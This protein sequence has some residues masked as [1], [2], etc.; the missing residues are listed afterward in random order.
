MILSHFLLIISTLFLLSTASPSKCP[1]SPL[2]ILL[3]QYIQDHPY[4]FVNLHRPSYA[5]DKTNYRP[6]WGIR[7]DYDITGLL[8]NGG[9]AK[10][11]K[12]YHDPTDKDVALKIYVH[13]PI[14][15]I[16]REIQ[17]LNELADAPNFLSLKDTL[18]DKSGMIGTVFDIFKMTDYQHLF[19]KTTEPQIRYFFYQTLRTLEY[20]H[21][22]G[23]MHRDIKPQNVMM[24]TDLLQM[25]LID[26][27]HAAYY[28]PGKEYDVKVAS[29]P[30]KGPELL[31]NYTLH[32]Y[33]TDIWS[34]GCLFGALLFRRMPFFR[35]KDYASQLDAIAKVLG[36]TKLRQYADKYKK[37]MDLSI[38]KKVG[39]YP[40][41][42]LKTLINSNNT[43]LVTNSAIDLLE[44]MLVYDHAKRITAKEALQH[45]YFTGL[46]YINF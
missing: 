44:Q 34:T 37:F 45:P 29:M 38:L 22:R 7:D 39:N 8:A 32:D 20:A 36:T 12:G 27:G 25:K 6:G 19:Y 35:G 10:V 5:S 9:F 31:L 13:S 11:F 43:H 33:S 24:N 15:S 1:S 40:S 28:F 18:K 46:E 17:I 42:K 2:Y 21:S 4:K 30:Y 41:I 16:Y 3:E 14:D 23:I 26:W